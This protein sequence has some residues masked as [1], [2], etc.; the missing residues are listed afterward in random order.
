MLNVGDKWN[1]VGHAAISRV[2]TSRI[3]N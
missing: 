2:F 1:A 3:I